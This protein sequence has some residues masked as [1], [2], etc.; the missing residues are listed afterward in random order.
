MAD[1]KRRLLVIGLD[2]YEPT[3]ADRMIAAGELPALADLRARSARFLLDHGEAKRTGLAWEHVATGLAPGAGGRWSAVDLDAR[4]YRAVQAPTR[5][6][7]FAADI[8]A[9]TVVFDAPYFDLEGAPGVQGLVS[10]GAHDPGV[11]PACRPAGLDREMAARFGA[12]PAQ[13]WIYGFTWPDPARCRDLARDL[14]RAVEVRSK[15]ARWLLAERLP[16]WDLA[17]VVVSECHSAVEPLWHGVDAAHPL[18][19]HPSAAAAGEGLREVYRAVDRLVGD[20]A[21]AFPDATLLAFAVHGMGPNDSD[22]ASM[23]LLP[24]LLYRQAF[25]RSH[26]R[27]IAWPTDAA[28]LPLL[29]PGEGWEQAMLR[30]VPLPPVDR[31][32]R[33]LLRR[34]GRDEGGLDW[35][36]AARY[37]RFWPAMD[38]F[39]LPAFYDGRIRLNLQGREAR[40]RVAPGDY[41]AACGR[42]ETLLRGCRDALTG[43][44]AVASIERAGGADPRA[45]D[46]SGCDLVVIWE[47]SPLGLVHPELGRIGPLPYRRTGGHTGRWGEALLAGPGI[48]PGGRGVRDSFDV[49]PTIIRLLGEPVPPGIAGTDLLAPE[50][51]PA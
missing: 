14:S 40:G 19:S 7:P 10:W 17:L 8:N 2:G 21:A 39:A 3:L 44:A 45:L 24:E 36:P 50:P 38:A 9:R 49:V 1:P 18:H 43:R 13:E 26:M 42:L 20:L 5:A 15:A 11:A 27:T 41:D 51:V 33:A 48:A 23:A 12:Y 37:R 4:R 46:P 6:R 28:G 34:L 29:E 47:G 25:G 32:R 16:D 31:A 30:A 22:V 35:M